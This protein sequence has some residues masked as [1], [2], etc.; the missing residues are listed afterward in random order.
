MRKRGEIV[1]RSFAHVLERGG[2]RR[3]WLRSRENVHKRYLVHVAG[4]NLGVLMRALFGAGTPRE[5]ANVR[6]AFLVIIPAADMIAF[7]ILAASD[8]ETAALIVAVTCEADM[9]KSRHFHRAGKW[10]PAC[11]TER[12]C[13][14]MIENLKKIAYLHERIALL[15]TKMLPYAA[16]FARDE[17][18]FQKVKNMRELLYNTD[19][20]FI[21]FRLFSDDIAMNEPA[22]E[23]RNMLVLKKMDCF[24]RICGSICVTLATPYN[25]AIL[26]LEQDVSDA[27]HPF[28]IKDHIRNIDEHCSYAEISRFAINVGARNN[29]NVEVMLLKSL[30]WCIQSRAKLFFILSDKA[31]VRLYRRVFASAGVECSVLEDVF[32]PMKPEYEGVKMCILQGHIENYLLMS[33]D[34]ESMQSRG[35][36]HA[37]MRVA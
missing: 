3:T 32:I 37:D 29:N 30:D 1:E 12:G 21:G 27:E 18:I 26:D 11:C 20:R 16:E 8:A 17:E 2:M 5:A 33:I 19:R 28:R 23:Y 4:Y 34:G 15:E 24:G 10:R 36:C 25:N 9:I 7:V 13:V 14:Q 35:V 22:A 6:F 31:R